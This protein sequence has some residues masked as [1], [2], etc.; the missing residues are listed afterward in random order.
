VMPVWEY[1]YGAHQLW[2]TPGYL[3]VMLVWEPISP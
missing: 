1:A 2:G 3:H